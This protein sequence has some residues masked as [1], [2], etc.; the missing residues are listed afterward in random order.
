MTRAELPEQARAWV[1][2]RVGGATSISAV[3]PLFGGIS[4]DTR[5]LVVERESGGPLEVVLKR[6]IDPGRASCVA[7]EAVA[8]AALADAPLTFGVARLLGRDDAGTECDVPALLTSRLPGRIALEPQ[9]WEPRVRALGEALAD[10]HAARLPCPASLRDYFRRIDEPQLPPPADAGFP[11]W[12][13][14]WR[15]VQQQDFS[16][17]ALLHGDYHLGNALFEGDELTGVV[18]WAS[19]RRGRAELEVAYCRLD[20]S[21]LLGG[22]APARFLDAYQDRAQ[23]SIHDVSRWDLGA[24]L[25]AFPDAT[26]WL[27]G[28]RDA[29]RTDLT[30]SLIRERLC[31]FV[32]SALRAI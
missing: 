11:D 1:L 3:A 5:G 26:P 21:M 28:W 23:R 4:A 15:F 30:P 22:D 6:F 29:G 18:D 13:A 10:F 9:G 20:L 8:L 17:D 27:E 16:G 25:R 7:W 14:V 12:K 32:H 19:V 31:G 24:S 2:A